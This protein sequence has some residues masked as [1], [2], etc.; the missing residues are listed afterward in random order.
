MEERPPVI[1][2]IIP[3]VDCIT[4]ELLHANRQPVDPEDLQVHHFMA[5]LAIELEHTYRNAQIIPALGEWHI[6]P[7]GVC[8]TNSVQKKAHRAANSIGFP[9]EIERIA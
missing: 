7:E 6:I 4:L 3:D 1:L 5:R 8:R 9:L 2:R